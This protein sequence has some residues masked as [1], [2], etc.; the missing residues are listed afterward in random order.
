[1]SD[2]DLS[3]DQIHFLATYLNVKVPVGVQTTILKEFEPEGGYASDNPAD[4]WLDA[5][6]KV[7]ASLAPLMTE[8]SKAEDPNLNRIARFGLS[9]VTKGNNTAL[10]AAILRFNGSSGPA[11]ASTATALGKEI[12]TYSNFLASD[13][14]VGLCEENPFGYAVAIRAPL[15]RALDKMKAM[16]AA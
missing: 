15:I 12:D 4:T 6:G 16:I 8:L 14:I 3:A 9:S 11:R 1:M 7:D 5:K 13:P 2:V 10:M